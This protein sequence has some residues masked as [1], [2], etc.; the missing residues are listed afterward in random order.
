MSKKSAPTRR[1]FLGSACC[2]AVG[3]T[4][5]VSTLAS[6]R[7]TA[8]A[9]SIPS[10]SATPPRGAAVASDYKALV[11][12]FLNG[13]NDSSNL[14]IPNDTSG[15][16]DYVKARTILALPQSNLLSIT[17]KKSDG[18]SFALHPST[19]ELRTLFN[20]GKLA[21]MANVG[22]LV[23]PT[24]KSQYSTNAVPLPPQLF[25]HADQQVQ[26][27]SSVPDQPF[28]TGWGGRTADLLNSL[29]TNAQVSMSMSLDSFNN[30]QVANTLS[31]LAV[32]R[33]SGATSKGGPIAFSGS[34]GNTTATTRFQ[35]QKDLFTASHRNLFA[36]AFGTLT[37]DAIG[38][39]DLLTTAL[40]A[41]PT[42]ATTFP[43]TT[44]AKQLKTIA[45]LISIS[46]TLNLK[47]QV[48]FARISGWDTHADQVDGNGAAAITGAHADLLAQVSQAMNAFYNATVE[49]GCANQVTTFTASDF[50]RTFTSNG[51]G[52]DHGWGG[53]QMVLGGAVKGGDIYG[54][55]PSPVVNGNDDTGFGRWIPTTSVDE[56]AATLATWFGVSATNLST[57]FP[58]I[59]RFA[60][61]NL[62]F[63]S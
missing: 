54:K 29:N 47:R 46:S 41:S 34:S 53:H 40:A 39:S 57:A 61:P 42:L 38:D 2:A 12:I 5:M 36:S 28:K 4:G 56:Y 19:T 37:A 33:S 32:Q 25:S 44:L 48:F 50:G 27:Q 23:H 35:A 43:V 14:I 13:G 63:L 30:F 55:M 8:A 11:C 60:K 3:L 15:Y 6:L 45:Y 18:R 52:S 49:L 24:T 26:W 20:S 59:G 21:L 10:G 17:P 7:A 62:G 58:N 9:A 22:T 16:A 31:Q 51:D 1:D